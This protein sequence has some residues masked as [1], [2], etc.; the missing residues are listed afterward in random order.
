MSAQ[1]K[2]GGGAALALAL[3]NVSVPGRLHELS[4]EVGAGKMVGL[5][6][7]NGSGKSTLLAVAAGLLP[8]VAPGVVRWAGEAVAGIPGLERGRRTAW[9]PQEAR[10]EFGFSVRSVVGQGRYAHGDDG[11]GVAEAL[12][13]FGLGRI[14]ERAVDRLSGGERHRVLLARAWA[15]GAALQLWDEPL[16]ALDPRHGLETLMLGRELTRAGRTLVFSLHDLRVA[17]C[18][19]EVVVLHEGR[20]RAAGAPEKVLTPELL[21]EVFGVTARVEPGLTLFL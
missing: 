3:E 10:F 18:L 15:T 17:H 6:G 13:R 7:P 5:V 19:D 20:L 9:V 4:L 16:A 12:E 2:G 11:A 8:S 14:A 21:R 1:G